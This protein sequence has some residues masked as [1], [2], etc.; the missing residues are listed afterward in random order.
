[1]RI[2]TYLMLFVLALGMPAMAHHNYRLNFD[3][4]KEIALDGV[5]AKISW[6]N[7]HITIYLDV[8]VDNG[9]VVS[10]VIPTA[11]PNVA[12]RNGLTDA[13][14]AA[15]DEIHIV[16]WPARDASLQM[17]AR[18]VKTSNGSEFLLHPTGDRRGR[19]RGE[20]NQEEDQ[21]DDQ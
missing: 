17:R 12:R 2:F 19:N 18:M 15:G 3:D 9:E 21:E 6:G 8:S 10:W 5:V 16:G 1:M 7:P 11:A 20:D 14:L 4:S 13:V